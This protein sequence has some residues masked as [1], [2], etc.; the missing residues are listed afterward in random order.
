M[1]MEKTPVRKKVGRKAK[2][3]PEQFSVKPVEKTK[4]AE[5]RTASL[6]TEEKTI[7]DRDS[8]PSSID[9]AS[10]ISQEIVYCFRSLDGNGNGRV[11]KKD[12]LTEL[13]STGLN[14]SDPRMLS[15]YE[16]AQEFPE[17]LDLEAFQDLCKDQIVLV[18]RALRG[19]LIIPDFPEFCKDIDE[20]YHATK[21]LDGGQVADYIPQLANIPAEKYAVSLCTVDGQRADWGDFKDSFSIQSICKT[22]NYVLALENFGQDKVHDHVGREPSGHS[23]NELTLN[24]NGRPHNPLINAG[25]IMAV[26][27]IKPKA[28]PA[29][30]FDYV[31]NT[32]KRLCGGQ[33]PGFNNAVYLSEKNTADR[34]YALAYFMRERKA[35][36]EDTQL[37]EVLDFYFQCCSLEMTTGAMATAAATLAN[38]GRCPLTN[39]HV[40]EAANVK[41]VLSLMSSCGMYDFSGEFAFSIGLPAKSGVGGG[42]MLV[43]PNTM[44]ICIWSPALDTQGNCVRGVEFC[45]RLVE[46]FNFHNFDSLVTSASGKKDPR[47]NKNDSK[48]RGVMA[49]CWAASQGDLQE[50]KHLI[51]AGVDPN[52]ADYDGRTAMHLAAS[53]GHKHVV[54]YFMCQNV[55]LTPKDRW[56]GTPLDDAKREGH[57]PLIELL[58]PFRAEELRETKPPQPH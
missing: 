26:S 42:L 13:K 48:L 11:R 32:W 58:A 40:F 17:I 22:I 38:A 7:Q 39:E 24:L 5:S 21:D 25:A 27:M 57:S 44:G 14:P 33:M 36:P 53:E 8:L 28:D 51:A 20:I 1:E 54:E 46:K 31:M 55:H 12:L 47:G 2:A 4:I 37:L 3:Q 19:E 45:R 52:E 16:S 29:T 41:D 23:F 50:V 15:L 34:N 9:P 35:F 43:I 6:V 56:G 10:E 30:R 49:L 18:E